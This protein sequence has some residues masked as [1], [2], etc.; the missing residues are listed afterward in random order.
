MKSA[1]LVYYAKRNEVS[2]ASAPDS[3]ALVFSIRHVVGEYHD[4]N[5]N[6]YMTIARVDRI[7]VDQIGNIDPN[8]EAQWGQYEDG[9]IDQGQ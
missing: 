3:G 1:K 5:G 6:L 9:P 7:P 4:K 8:R 2:C